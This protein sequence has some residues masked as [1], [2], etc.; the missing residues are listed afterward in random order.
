[1]NEFFKKAKKS[2]EDAMALVRFYHSAASGMTSLRS[3]VCDILEIKEKNLRYDY[4]DAQHFIFW[5]S[6]PWIRK[7]STWEKQ[8][9]D[10]QEFIDMS[11]PKSV[12][13]EILDEITE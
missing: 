1:M 13:V 6:K 4:V 11:T 12:C 9:K 5:I 3:K 7:T 10:A 2:H 8:K